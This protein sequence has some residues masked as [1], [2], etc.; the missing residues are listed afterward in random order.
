MTENIII[1]YVNEKRV[2]LKVKPSETVLTILHK[3]GYLGTKESC[4]EGDCGSC[5]IAINNM[6]KIGEYK[7][8]T[9]CIL[10][11]TKLHKR[12]IITVEGLGKPDDTHQIQQIIFDNHAT[13]C[14]FC[15]PGIIMSLFS[16]LTEKTEVSIDTL[17]KS[18]EGNICRCTGYQ[19]IIEASEEIIKNVNNSVIDSE[20]ILPKYCKNIQEK[21]AEIPENIDQV[22]NPIDE[23]INIKSYSLLYSI[24]ELKKKLSQL[25]NQDYKITSGATDLFVEKNIQKKYHDHYIDI[26]RIKDFSGIEIIENAIEIGANEPIEN[27]LHNDLI[28][29]KIPSLNKAIFWMSSRQIRNVATLAGNIG[30]ASPIGDASSALVG[31]DASLLLIS[32]TQE[33]TVKLEDYFKGYKSTILEKNE[34]IAKIIIPIEQLNTF[35]NFIK[36]TKR[37]NLDI[38]TVNSFCKMNVDS[39]GKII[40]IR[41]VYGG[42]AV[43]PQLAN[44]AITELINSNINELDFAKIGTL[45]MDDFKPISDVRASNDYRNLLIKNH[46]I[47]H[48]AIYKMELKNEK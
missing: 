45:L 16:K 24:D 18:L 14:G 23:V 42:V 27:L 1:F 48:I 28:K 43:Y 46:L 21:L 44:N 41:L 15:T 4:G 22:E 7:A 36:T 12:H 11:A 10:P 31:L 5:T 32:P 3:L 30:N 17:K 2:K 38:S 35:Y 19:H 9:S 25:S 6:D 39:D 20:N 40:D 34:V 33:R 8:V 13:Q 29:S 37:K 26:S 47:K